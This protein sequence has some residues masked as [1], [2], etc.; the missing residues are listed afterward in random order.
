MLEKYI[1][2]NLRAGQSQEVPEKLYETS[3]L[4]VGGGASENV[5][6]LCN[7]LFG[8]ALAQLSQKIWRASK[9]FGQC[10]DNI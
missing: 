1:L 3:F 10:S 2:Q 6:R 4:L 7:F 9:T 5:Q 8:G